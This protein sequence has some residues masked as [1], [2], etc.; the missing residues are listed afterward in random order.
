M[1][2]FIPLTN[3]AVL[4]YSL[5]G[6]KGKNPLVFIN[7]LGS[8]LRI[9]D[10]VSALLASDF[11]IL[12][13]DKRGHGLS[14]T[15]PGPY[16][17]GDH[18][19]DLKALLD[20]LAIHKAILIGISVG[21]MIA[22][23]FAIAYPERTE[24]LV[25]CDT[26]AKIGTAEMWNSRIETIQA[27][28]LAEVAKTVIDRWFTPTF[29]ERHS[30]EARGYFNMLSRTPTQGYI[31][32]CMALRD[33]DLRPQLKH[34]KAQTLVLCGDQDL[35]TPPELGQELAQHLNAPFELIDHAGH[36]PCIEQPQAMA[37][38]IR[39]FLREKGTS[40][41]YQKGIKTRREVLGDAHVDR[42][43]A[44]KTEF[45]ADFQ[46]FITEYAWG[47]LWQRGG[48]DRKTRHLIT[49]GL[50]AALG[51]ESE[52]AMH[53]RATVNTGVTPNEVREALHQVAVYAGVPAANAAFGVAK[54][55]YAEMDA[56][57]TAS[58]EEQR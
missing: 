47:D 21:G 27:Q 51:K 38:K 55:V 57:R 25:L 20:K 33:A 48:I 18:T 7:S 56:V 29:F 22:Q 11:Q 39:A 43:E 45:D 37:A 35:S 6:S 54:K 41:K 31:G 30:S 36:L 44:N 26:G 49:I 19:H 12:C 42:A 50:I 58:R 1:K 17:I 40:D 32:T 2:A 9:W 34:I 46:R 10:E 53:I 8:D 15:P 4:H 28:G 13:Y 3:S 14:D 5:R 23:D 16:T 24:A 52:L